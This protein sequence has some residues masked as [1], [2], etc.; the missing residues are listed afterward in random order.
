MIPDGTRPPI[1]PNYAPAF[2]R[3]HRLKELG[4]KRD[5]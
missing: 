3:E 2:A 5:R 1:D 4:D